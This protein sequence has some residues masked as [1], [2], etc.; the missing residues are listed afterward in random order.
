MLS[1]QPFALF[2]NDK[3]ITSV[4]VKRQFLQ[5]SLLDP[6][7]YKPAVPAAPLQ[8]NRHR[9]RLRRVGARREE[10][11]LTHIS[12]SAWSVAADGDEDVDGDGG[13]GVDGRAGSTA[14]PRASPAE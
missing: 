4:M 8:K 10:L 11:G 9:C 2:Q 14:V 13:V 7:V 12:G 1:L 3:N 6:C 5:H